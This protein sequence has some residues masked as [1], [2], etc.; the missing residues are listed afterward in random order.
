MRREVPGVSNTLL[1][2]VDVRDVAEMILQAMDT[3]IAAGKRFIANGATIPLLEFANILRRNF[4]SRGYRVPTTVLP[5]LMIRL[6]AL[7]VP[8]LKNVTDQLDWN[9][10]LS[11][12]QA[13]TI[14]GWQPRSYEGTI[15]EMAESLIEHKLV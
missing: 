10:S 3:P 7:L 14:L 15:V 12:E 11:T 1:N 6:M 13:R 8:K 4:A 9:Y 5:D 2:F